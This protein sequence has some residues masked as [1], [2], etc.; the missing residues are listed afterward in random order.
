MYYLGIDFGKKGGFALLDDQGRIIEKSPMPIHIATKDIDL[1]EVEAL[2]IKWRALTKDSKVKVLGEKLHAIFGSSAKATFSF[3]SDYG[4]LKGYVFN[5]FKPVNLVRA[6]DWQK[7]VWKTLEIT[8]IKKEG[9]TRNDTKAMALE[10]IK[11]L[12]PEEDFKATNRSK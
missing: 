6:V 1:Y 12:Y 4:L 11:K 5:Y 2:M 10:A 3:G 9:S 8:P 7:Y